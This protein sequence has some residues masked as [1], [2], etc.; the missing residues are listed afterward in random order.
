[1]IKVMSNIATLPKRQEDIKGLPL[2]LLS[3]PLV[4]IPT[5]IQG[6]NYFRIE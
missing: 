3:V 1:M 2:V 6:K 5:L 4:I